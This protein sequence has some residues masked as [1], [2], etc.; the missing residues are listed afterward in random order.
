[1]LQKLSKYEVKSPNNKRFHIPSFFLG[2]LKMRGPIAVI[3]LCTICLS[4]GQ[5]ILDQF[6]PK[7]PP[8]RFNDAGSQRACVFCPTP[9]TECNW[10][11]SEI[12]YYREQE[13]LQQLQ[14]HNVLRD[15]AELKSKDQEITRDDKCGGAKQNDFHRWK[16][17]Q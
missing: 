6:L 11:E 15:I 3:F 16:S 7:K 9:D 10:I 17:E 14:C 5:G 8:P 2:L 1:M 12:N 4:Q 13:G